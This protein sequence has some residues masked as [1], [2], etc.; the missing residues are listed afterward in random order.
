MLKLVFTYTGNDLSDVDWKCFKIAWSV[1][2]PK[3][4]TYISDH[5]ALHM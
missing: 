3:F 4:Y 2:G 1:T 5:V